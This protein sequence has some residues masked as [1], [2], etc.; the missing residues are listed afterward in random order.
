MA[1]AISRNF[2]NLLFFRA[3]EG[4]GETFYFPASMSLISDYHGQDHTFP[5]DGHA[6]D[7]RLRRHYR[8]RL[9][10]RAYRPALWLA[11]VV[12]RLRRLAASCSALCSTDF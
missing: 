8:G 3:A 12:H 9:F 10:R 7:Q 6:P 5:R 11:V 1:T 2:G 4:L